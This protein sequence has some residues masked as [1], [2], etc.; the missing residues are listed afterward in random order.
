MT[1][2]FQVTVDSA[3]PHDLADWWAETL[4]WELEP[5]DEQFIR[6]MVEAGHATED[7]TL[8][9]D[10]VLVWR[11]GAAIRH[12][13][14]LPGA[15]RVLFQHV[16]EAKTVKNRLH[17][18]V[19]TGSDDLEGEVARL[20]ARGATRLHDGRQGPSVWVTLQDPQ[21]NEFCVSR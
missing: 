12:P 5:S 2:Y 4:G 9:H 20:V 11:A 14:Q 16:P 6:R 18:D 7:D 19:R 13:E 15:P 17:L 10:G 3:A 21:G 1:Y 8:T